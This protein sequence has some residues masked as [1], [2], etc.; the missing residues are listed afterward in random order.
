[1]EPH[2]GCDCSE[3]WT[4]PHCELL[5][6]AGQQESLTPSSQSEIP[7]INNN[8]NSPRASPIETDALEAILVAISLVLLVAII[9][10]ALS[11]VLRY[12][13]RKAAM[14]KSMAIIGA[15]DNY[16]DEPNISPYRDNAADPIPNRR[17]TSSSSDPFTTMITE[18]ETTRQVSR[19]V[20]PATYLA[21]EADEE[22][23]RLQPVE[24]W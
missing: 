6:K 7:S 4:G 10:C 8:D 11:I 1:V 12:W 23:N 16:E 18:S 21:S 17:H 5:V 22:N 14:S 2:P 9:L 15:E 19:M 20:T 3:K 24:L 13:R